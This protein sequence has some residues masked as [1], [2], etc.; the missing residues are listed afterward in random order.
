MVPMTE[1]WQ[2]SRQLCSAATNGGQGLARG[3]VEPGAKLGRLLEGVEATND[4]Q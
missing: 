2:G 4:Q 3:G 1:S